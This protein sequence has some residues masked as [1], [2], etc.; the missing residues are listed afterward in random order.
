MS[1]LANKTIAKKMFSLYGRNAKNPQLKLSIR[2]TYEYNKDFLQ[3]TELRIGSFSRLDINSF[4]F[5]YMIRYCYKD[6]EPVLKNTNTIEKTSN[7]N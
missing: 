2:T 3:F 4:S 6:L 5:S 7:L 1:F